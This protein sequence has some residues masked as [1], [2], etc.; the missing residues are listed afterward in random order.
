M[1][2]LMAFCHE[3]STIIA[4]IFGV[5]IAGPFYLGIFCL[6]VTAKHEDEWIEKEYFKVKCDDD[7]FEVMTH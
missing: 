1:G 3:Y 5:I 6:M 7:G 2:A 4:F